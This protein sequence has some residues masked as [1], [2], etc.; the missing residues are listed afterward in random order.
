M[1][2]APDGRAAAAPY[3]R[4][5]S[6]LRTPNTS[7]LA[8]IA[9]ADAMHRGVI[10]CAP[11]SGLATV[12]ATM[13]ANVVHAAVLLAPD[14]DRAVAVTDL[15]VIRAALRGDDGATAAEIGRESM[16]TVV[17]S[18]P[19]GEAVTLMARREDTHLLVSEPGAAWPVGVLS[20]LNVMAA[21]ADRDPSLLRIVRPGP[22]RPLVSAT[23]LA[24]TTVGA[25]M[26]PGVVTCV[27]DDTMER[28]AGVMAD[29]RIHCV[30][31]VG[32]ARRNGGDEHFVWGL[33]SDMDVLHAVNRGGPDLTA[34]EVALTSPLA[35]PEGAALDRA[36]SLMAEHDAT[37]LVVVDR[38]GTPVGVVSTL[39]VLRILAA[40]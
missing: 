24:A 30:A 14:R 1:V 2:G 12:A 27:P 10:T 32:A 26:H 29:L 8:A 35:L 13:A 9:V 40:V 21:L 4:C 36:A 37:H 28:V 16:A 20:S 17:S 38:T 33:L 15:D 3:R 22:A 25:V 6:A 31:V 39:D 34:G 18:A 5:M 23:S 11:E 7:P 19:L